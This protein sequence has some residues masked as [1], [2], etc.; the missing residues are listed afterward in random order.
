MNISTVEIKKITASEGMVLTNGTAFSSVGGSVYLGKND[1]VENWQ[2]VSEEEYEA[3]MA[4]KAEL[5]E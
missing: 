5:T 3:A 1:S 2:E 4:A